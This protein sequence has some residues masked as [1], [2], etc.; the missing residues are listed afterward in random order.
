MWT[1]TILFTLSEKVGARPATHSTG[2][3][4][5][6]IISIQRKSIEGLAGAGGDGGTILSE[7]LG[8]KAW[9]MQSSLSHSFSHF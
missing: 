3:P 2:S 8:P 6:E 9:V 7:S 1:V 5:Q 4:W